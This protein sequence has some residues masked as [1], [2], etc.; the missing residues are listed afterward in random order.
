[1]NVK[2][3]CFY[4]VVC[5]KWKMTEKNLSLLKLKSKLLIVI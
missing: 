5:S 4:K 3:I 2:C 1:M